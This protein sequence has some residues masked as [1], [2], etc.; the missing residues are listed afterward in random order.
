MTR[1]RSDDRSKGEEGVG[2]GNMSKNLQWVRTSG[3]S[4][5]PVLPLEV[6]HW[7]TPPGPGESASGIN[8][9]SRRR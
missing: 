5:E 9:E 6:A 2:S 3:A 4:E 7:H 1:I 8:Q